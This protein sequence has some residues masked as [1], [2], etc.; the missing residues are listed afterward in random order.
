LNTVV[1]IVVVNCA[2]NA[3]FFK[4]FLVIQPATKYPAFIVSSL[5]ENPDV[6]KHKPVD[7]TFLLDPFSYYLS[8][9]TKVFKTFFHEA[10][11]PE[12][13][14]AF[15]I[16]FATSHRSPLFNHSRFIRY[17]YHHH[18]H[19]HHHHHHHHHLVL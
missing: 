13:L 2:H 15:V 3:A 1:A 8:I 7:T 17:Y 9:L 4:T 16:Y 6:S 14:Y 18:Y 19:H 10:S 5:Q 12:T 11:R